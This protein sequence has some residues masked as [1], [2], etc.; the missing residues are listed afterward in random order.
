MRINKGN[1]NN[2]LKEGLYKVN[3]T[4]DDSESLSEDSRSTDD[5][6]IEEE[7]LGDFLD[8][9]ASDS[10]T[11]YPY[12]WKMQAAFCI[13]VASTNLLAVGFSPIAAV[14]SALF[15]CSVRVV[16]A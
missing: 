8:Y 4:S 12:R 16:E 14:V 11:L 7:E 1:N 3:S 13:A 9:M 5:E 10:F 15:G 2:D 6:E